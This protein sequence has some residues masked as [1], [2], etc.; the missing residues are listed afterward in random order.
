MFPFLRLYQQRTQHYLVGSVVSS[1]ADLKLKLLRKVS[2][3]RS[4]ANRFPKF[5]PTI[6][7]SIL[8]SEQYNPVFSFANRLRLFLKDV[9]NDERWVNDNQS[10][11]ENFLLASVFISR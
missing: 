11:S 4:R 3:D 8:S 2:L 10:L 6:G 7:I 5:D 9:S 1:A